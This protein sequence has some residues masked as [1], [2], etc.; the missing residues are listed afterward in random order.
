[1]V[2]LKWKG[3]ICQQEYSNEGRA[4]D[5]LRLQLHKRRSKGLRLGRLG[6]VIEKLSANGTSRR[7]H[8]ILQ[9]FM[10]RGGDGSQEIKMGNQ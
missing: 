5:D 7:P 8:R 9:M 4:D 6:H 1:M 2:D 3:V 10:T